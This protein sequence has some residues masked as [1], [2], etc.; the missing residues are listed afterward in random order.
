MVGAAVRWRALRASTRSTGCVAGRS[1]PPGPC[2]APALLGRPPT[3]T[4]DPQQLQQDHAHHSIRP[5]AATALL[6]GPQGSF[7][8][9]L[10]LEELDGALVSF[11]GGSAAKRAEIAAPARAWVRCSRVQTAFPRLQLANHAILIP[12]VPASRWRWS[13]R[14]RAAVEPQDLP[15]SNCARVRVSRRMRR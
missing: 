4:P 10:A 15:R 1:L 7:C 6:Q 14:Q 2:Q 11:R 8:S 12:G 5:V 9:M 3:P 13:A